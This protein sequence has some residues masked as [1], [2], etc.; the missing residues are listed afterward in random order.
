MRDRSFLVIS[1]FVQLAEDYTFDEGSGVRIGTFAATAGLPAE[2]VIQIIEILAEQ[3]LDGEHNFLDTI[4]RV[5]TIATLTA[6]GN[7]ATLK[8]RRAL[9]PALVRWTAEWGE[10]AKCEKVILDW[11]KK[12]AI[13]QNIHL[14]NHAQL[15]LNAIP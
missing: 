11:V 12:D 10:H 4:G 1:W 13:A 9:Y 15:L 3:E 6:W 8:Q 7:D 2:Q 14:G 5:A